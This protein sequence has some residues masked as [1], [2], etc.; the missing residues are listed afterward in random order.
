MKVNYNNVR[1]QAILAHDNLVQKLN[2]SIVKD[3][4]YADV[5]G[6]H[7][8]IKGFVLIDAK[9]IE[10]QINTLRQMIGTMAMTAIDGDEDFKDVY[11]ELFPKEEQ[12][13]KLFNQEEDENLII[14]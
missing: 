1:K 3:K 4:Q 10:E 5:D 14:S 7:C 6:E 13:M 8:C 9:E 12:G 2:K 11:E